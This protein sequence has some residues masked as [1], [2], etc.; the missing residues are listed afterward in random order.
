MIYLGI[1]GGT[2]KTRAMAMDEHGRILGSG[3]AGPSNYQVCG[4]DAAMNNIAMAIQ[5][6]LTVA[7]TSLGDVAH[8]VFGL[9]GMDLP[10]HRTALEEGLR[11]AFPALPF[12]LVNDTWIMLKGGSDRGWGIA[13]VCGGG[14]NACACDAAGTWVTMRGLGYESG[15]R[16]GGLD[17]LRDVLHYAF[18]SHDGTGPRSCLEEAVLQ[19]TGASDYDTLQLQLLAAMQDLSGN[20]ELL[21]RALE[22]LPLVFRAASDGDEAC[23]RILLQQG[24]SLAEG[25]LGLIQ[26]LH[27]EQKEFDIVL[28]GSL[29]L[30]ENPLLIDQLTLLVHETAPRA[31]LHRPLLDPVCGACLMAMERSG[32]SP[33]RE[34]YQTLA[35]E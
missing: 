19:A 8:A 29:F 33:D 16:G 9:S 12:T 23:C 27:L 7:G 5:G 20:A 30:G 26:R 10:L 18:L 1:D 2:Y 28:G 15:M 32:L 6:T 22:V 34:L 21:H 31:H 13:L 35:R 11:T 17:M 25:V 4:L 14:A 3:E 24:T